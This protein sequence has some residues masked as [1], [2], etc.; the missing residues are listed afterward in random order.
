MNFTLWQ[1]GEYQIFGKMAEY[2]I[3]V[4]YSLHP[5]FLEISGI[6]SYL[7]KDKISIFPP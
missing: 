7:R 2:R 1:N 6:V 3:V 4:E 5:Y